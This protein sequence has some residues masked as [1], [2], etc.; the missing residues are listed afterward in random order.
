L[1]VCRLLQPSMSPTSNLLHAKLH[2]S[3]AGCFLWSYASSFNRLCPPPPA[4]KRLQPFC[5][6]S[7]GWLLFVATSTRLTPEG[8][9][10]QQ[11]VGATRRR[12]FSPP[13]LGSSQW[14]S[15]SFDGGVISFHFDLVGRVLGDGLPKAPSIYSHLFF[16][17]PWQ[18]TKYLL[19]SYIPSQKITEFT[20]KMDNKNYNIR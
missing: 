8:K 2:S 3:L 1:A 20:K 13:S 17:S 12:F 11:G 7:N 6:P 18:D 15:R 5:Q 19:A 14:I 10:G 4:A 16:H 9:G